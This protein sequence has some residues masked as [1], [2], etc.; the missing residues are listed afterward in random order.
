M[1]NALL[2]P[3]VV[4]SIFLACSSQPESSQ[5]LAQSKPTDV[6]QWP[7]AANYEI[8][9]Q[10]F[11]DSDGDGIGDLNGVT[12]KLDYLHDLGVRGL[13]LMPISPSPSYHKYD[14]TD[15][16]GIHPDYG[17]M[18]DFKNLLT[19]AH[20]RDMKVIID[21]VINHTAREHPWFQD[22]I[23]GPNSPY[24]NYYVW[25]DY[26]SIEDQLSKKTVTLDSDNLTQWHEAAGNKQRYYGFFW[27][28]MPDLNYDNPAVKEEIFSTG[29][30]WLQEIGVD[31]FRLDAARHIFPD[32]RPEDNHNFW[33]EFR[34]EMEKAKPDVFLLGEV[35]STAEEVA[36][37]LKGLHSTF[38]FDLGYAITK[39]VQTGKA[40]SLVEKHQEITQ[41]YQRV[42]PAYIDATFLTNHDQNRII[43]ELGKQT[44]KAK[45]AAA[46]LLTMPG[47]PFLY[48]GEEIGMPGAKPD[49]NIREP[50]LWDVTGKDAIRTSWIKP[51]HATDSVVSPLSTQVKDQQSLYHH[52]RNLLHQRNASHALTDGVMDPAQTKAEGVVSFTRTKGNEQLLVLHNLTAEPK[53]FALA[54][55]DKVFGKMKFSTSDK[56]ALDKGLVT[57][58]PYA[59]LIVAQ[60]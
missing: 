1:K 56:A 15:Y 29:R 20:K 17:T 4:G 11:A 33:V 41:Y 52:Y 44:N 54:E 24:R 60:K 32:D 16:R 38:N 12:Q 14:V 46:L 51:V 53:Q 3:M 43:S 36:P 27:G 10:S 6:S 40:D 21:F 59:S 8:F 45:V 49:E 47:S 23:K 5:E 30:Y 37:Y 42:T 19:E 48:Y 13:W 55:A 18:E 22:A 28:G 57:L 31:G 2:L 50:F 25:A 58:P 26:D 9:V 7:K 39:A 35:W 34:R